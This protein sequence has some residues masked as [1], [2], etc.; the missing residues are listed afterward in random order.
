MGEAKTRL[1]GASVDDFLDTIEN[2]QVRDDCRTIARIIEKAAKAPP[3]F[4]TSWTSSERTRV[5]RG[6]CIS[7]VCRTST[8]RR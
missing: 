8:C 6:V 1:T 5:A 4:A 3:R 7:S 2:D